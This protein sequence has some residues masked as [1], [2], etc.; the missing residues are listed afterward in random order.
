MPYATNH[1][2]IKTALDKMH[3]PTLA[4]QSDGN[5]KHRV[6]VQ[7][8]GVQSHI[9]PKELV[10]QQLERTQEVNSTILPISYC[11]RIFNVRLE[12]KT[13]ICIKGSRTSDTCQGR[14]SPRSLDIISLNSNYQGDSGGPV[15]LNS[16]KAVLGFTVF[17][18][19]SKGDY[20]LKCAS[21][22]P[23]V[24]I[25]L[26]PFVPLINVAINT[27]SKQKVLDTVLDENTTH[28]C[29][30]LA[31]RRRLSSAI[32]KKPFLHFLLLLVPLSTV[33]M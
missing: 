22:D 27:L 31:R 32:T 17:G 5:Q 16:N 11:E 13:H 10:Y 24:G 21:G 29:L 7:S 8:V 12:H 1:R 2:L 3:F 30:S 14:A 15:V 4:E 18:S 33:F 19:E 20:G 9:D 26:A 28:R 25:L 23:S 6:R